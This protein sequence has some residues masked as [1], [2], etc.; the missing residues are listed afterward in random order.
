MR[1]VIIPSIH[2]T[3][4]QSLTTPVHPHRNTSLRVY[5]LSENRP[6]NTTLAVQHVPVTVL[7]RQVTPQ[8]GVQ[9]RAHV[10]HV[11][12]LG[13]AA[14]VVRGPDGEQL[15]VAVRAEG[16]LRGEQYEPEQEVLVAAARPRVREHRVEGHLF[17]D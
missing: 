4:I 1:L 7:P 6:V 12:Q 5:S 2:L 17:S 16:E 3:P 15:R 9:L 14:P 11:F 8:L 10:G 13:D